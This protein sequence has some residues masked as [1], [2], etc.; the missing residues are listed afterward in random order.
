MRAEDGE[1]ARGK[2]GVLFGVIGFGNHENIIG[3]VIC[4][5]GIG[6]QVEEVNG[7]DNPSIYETDA[8]ACE[9]R[10]EDEYESI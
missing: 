2:P 8:D 1:T 5:E 3:F 4:S 7:I 6:G 10:D 9:E